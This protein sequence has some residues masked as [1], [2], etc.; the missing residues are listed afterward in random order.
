VRRRTPVGADLAPITLTFLCSACIMIIEMVAG[1]VAARHVGNSIYNWT[2]IIAVVLLGIS[3]GNLM[4]G[5]C[6]DRYYRLGHRRLTGAFLACASLFTVSILWMHAPLYDYVLRAGWSWPL[7]VLTGALVTFLAPSFFLGALSP[8]LASWALGQGGRSGGTLGR[9]YAAGACGS[10]IGT[11]IAGFVLVPA[12]ATST[13]FGLVALILVVLALVVWP[14]VFVIATALCV[15]VALLVAGLPAG[16]T[17]WLDRLL[18]QAG[19]PSDAVYYRESAYQSIVVRYR[20]GQYILVMDDLING[21]YNPVE[22][23]RLT[24]PYLRVFRDLLARRSPSDS[25]V[26]SLHIGGGAYTFPRYI[27]ANRPND[28]VSVIE[29]D[30]IVTEVNVQVL[31][32]QRPPPFEVIHMDGRQAVTELR[33]AGR[34]Y[35]V[36]FLDAYQGFS[37]PFHLATREFY[38]EL[39]DLLAADGVVAANVIDEFES[40]RM[41]GG[42]YNTF[43]SV[44]PNIYVFSTDEQGPTGERETFVVVASKLPLDASALDASFGGEFHLL[45]GEELE[46]IKQRTRGL[47]FTD[48]YAPLETLAAR[49]LR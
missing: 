28:R 29:L 38:A 5:W 15:A 31:R 42:I 47:I 19:L 18:P 3:I 22:P 11:L 6:A 10:I 43:S 49:L 21:Y 4:G 7:T 8:L 9:I 27:A 23:S 33:R 13:I 12:L 39:F 44:F 45:T 37:T 30:P 1:R 35:D 32:L 26:T 46:H 34:K 24:Y 16:I 14:N 17:R 48:E 41:L 20:D 2:S 25:G 36:V 40:A